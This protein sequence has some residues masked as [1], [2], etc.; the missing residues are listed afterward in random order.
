MFLLYQHLYNEAPGQKFMPLLKSYRESVTPC[1][2]GECTVHQD[3][4]QRPQQT[5]PTWLD[6]LSPVLITCIKG[7][8]NDCVNVCHVWPVEEQAAR[9]LTLPQ[10]GILK[11]SGAFVCDIRW[12]PEV[13]VKTGGMWKL[14]GELRDLMVPSRLSGKHTA[15]LIS[16]AV[17]LLFYFHIKNKYDPLWLKGVINK[18][19]RLSCV[20][21]RVLYL[22]SQ[23]WTLYYFWM[24][25]VWY[26]GGKK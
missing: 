23:T 12:L 8:E 19:V 16:N 14:F 13:P 22:P 10:R 5:H 11:Q 24:I 17:L 2:V 9:T 7:S 1:W 15:V 26:Q 25:A 4:L 20:E 3:P 21:A 18:A 6:S